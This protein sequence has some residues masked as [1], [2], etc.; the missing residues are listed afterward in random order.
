MNADVLRGKWNEIKGGIREKWGKPTD[1]DL[2]QVEGK[3]E[4]LLGLLQKRYGYTREKA[5]DEFEKFM[6]GYGEPPLSRK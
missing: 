4:Q 5:Q 3:E 6:A 1:D 2:I